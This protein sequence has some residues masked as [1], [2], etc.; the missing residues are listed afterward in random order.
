MACASPPPPESTTGDLLELR[1][2]PEVD[3][4]DLPDRCR[5]LEIALPP[6]LAI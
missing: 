3:E 1:V 4:E 6:G 2:Y 5:P